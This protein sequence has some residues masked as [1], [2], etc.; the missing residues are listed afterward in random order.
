MSVTPIGGHKKI[1]KDV[2]PP[3]AQLKNYPA[4]TPM[5]WTGERLPEMLW[6]SIT[7]AALGRDEA[8][9]RFR[10]LARFI[11]NRASE[12]EG[13][14]EVLYKV[15]LSGL[16]DWNDQE[17]NG[18]VET[19]VRND[20]SI[21]SALILFDDLPGLERWKSIIP[22]PENNALDILKAAV[23]MTIWHQ[24]QASTDCR[25]MRV[26]GLVLGGHLKIPSKDLLLE[27]LEYPQHGDQ[28]KVRPLIRS[29][30][31]SADMGKDG[32]ERSTWSPKFWGAAFAM[33][34][35]DHDRLSIAANAVNA[36]TTVDKVKSV[37]HALFLHSEA[38]TSGT[39]VDARHEAS[40]GLA[41]YSLDVLLELLSL[42]NS[43]SI[44]GR[45]GLRSLTELL[46]NFTTLAKR[47]EPTRWQKFRDYGYGQAKL[48]YLKLLETETL[49]EFATIET[50][51]ALSNEDLWHEFREI[52]IGNWADSDLRSMSESQGIK[53]D[54]YD[55][56][57]DWS[58]AFV[59]GNWAA[60]RDAEY[61]LCLNPLHR[62][63]RVVTDNKKP[64]PDVVEDATAM[65]NR[66]LALLDGLYPKFEERV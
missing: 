30:E 51:E 37:R 66:A 54:T 25:W 43:T 48:A 42:S 8:L 46:I 33:T 44:V 39:S 47:D 58:S 31:G 34:R 59:H 7:I 60:V 1:G 14:G 49:P 53:D 12:N 10:F 63:H 32:I 57:Y 62:L 11:Q 6:A 26:L 15:T 64:L 29:M 45:M 50:L 2:I 41:A 55:K 38:T 17:F 24:T 52:H 23:A 4:Y 61:D 20:A 18:F 9:D 65:V 36:A 19:V 56:Y 3:L 16:A 21:F 27:I 22:P 5:D 40:F 13:R 35:D 28:Q